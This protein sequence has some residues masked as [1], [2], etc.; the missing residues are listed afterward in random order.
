MSLDPHNK[1]AGVHPDLVRVVKAA[2]QEPQAF[3]IVYGLRTIRAEAEAVA[4]GHSETMH[5]RHLPD[6]HYANAAMAVDFACLT[7]GAVDW[8]VADAQGGIYGQAAKQI[9][10]AAERLGVKCQWGGAAVGAWVDG[11]VSHFHDW[12]HI[13]LDPSEYP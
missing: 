9:L 10:D 8:T 3:E 13:Q 4:T 2:A 6:D 11:Q 1:L 12:G 5:S 7:N